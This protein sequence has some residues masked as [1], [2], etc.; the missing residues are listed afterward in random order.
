VARV[1][2]LRID[3]K[4]RIRGPARI[5]A[6]DCRMKHILDEDL[7]RLTQPSGHG[8]DGDVYIYVFYSFSSARTPPLSISVNSSPT[9]KVFVV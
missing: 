8:S 7:L 3:P 9:L 4:G 6:K 5:Y 2:G 1:R